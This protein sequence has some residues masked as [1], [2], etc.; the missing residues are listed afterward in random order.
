[1][2]LRRVEAVRFGGLESVSLGDLGPGLTVVLGP[3]EAGKSTFTALVR[4]VLYGFP[5]RSES[6]AGYESTA[7]KR[8]GR[9]VLA[10]A[11]GEWVVERTEG[12]HGGP[13]TVHAVAGPGRPDLPD[14]LT[15]GVSRD[16]YRVVFGFGLADLAEIERG[17][18]SG[19][20]VIA[21]LYA[22]RVGLAVSPQDVKAGIEREALDL[23]KP[24]GT[25]PLVNTLKSR[26]GQLRGELRDLEDRAAGF[27]RERARLDDLVTRRDAART[28]RDEATG[29]VVRLEGLAAGFER[30]EERESE[31]AGALAS[32]GAAATEAGRGLERLDVDERVLAVAPELDATLAELSGFSARLES[33]AAHDAVMDEIRR[34]AA[35]ALAESGLTA[36]EARAADIGPDTVAGVE[37]WRD[38]LSRLATRAET[39]STAATQARAAA[40]AARSGHA[41]GVAAP[42]APGSRIVWLVAIVLGVFA[43]GA[44]A[45]SGQWV[46]I[47]AGI[48]FA[49]AGLAGLALSW[50]GPNAPPR[51]EQLKATEYEHESRVATEVAAEYA[52]EYEREHAAWRVWL[53]SRG[54]SGAGDYPVAVAQLIGSLK[55]WRRLQADLIMRTDAR[56]S[57]ET[58][59]RA[60][61]ARLAA[62]V[63]SF[64][65][66][67]LEDLGSVSALAARAR[68]ALDDALKARAAREVLAAELQ[69]SVDAATDLQARL[70]VVR[71]ELGE[72]RSTANPVAGSL[73]ARAFEQAARQE[74]ATAE[75]TYAGLADEVARLEGELGIVADESRMGELRLQLTAAQSELEA[76]AEDYAVRAL[77]SRLLE[78][79]T[80]EYERTRQPEVI[81]IAGEVLE[82]ITSGRYT[83]VAVP[84][85]GQE[86]KVLDASSNAKTTAELS[87]GTQEQ[88]YLALRIALIRQLGDVGS[89]LPVLMDDILVNFDPE[90]RAGAARAVVDLAA[91]RQVVFFTCHPETAELFGSIDT[92]HTVLTLDR[93]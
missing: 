51:G 28:V 39:A 77:A 9:L 93:C 87:R 67:P 74:R 69:R 52:V 65:P 61:A 78:L 49:L 57:D 59:C 88:L 11:D 55:E 17:R 1:V 48:V 58:A 7:G 91:E 5:K 70:D 23:F 83:R 64:L 27:A 21:R 75:E 80:E 41:R 92:G 2:K 10:D 32:A 4:S 50:F 34:R 12:P 13:V 42:G 85:S 90:R 46:A 60:Y 6:E 31:L 86:I 45:A 72:L 3:N 56:T 33:L 73:E 8:Q 30:L 43:A 53:E 18:G 38:T 54:I 89:G 81:R 66:E 76:A 22:A 84:S 82:R 62:T 40:E 79:T 19:D 47:V 44:G 37:Q 16:A 29:E 35:T 68:V 20:D 14:A 26:M 24:R 36:E 15:A 71:A 25:T 63:G